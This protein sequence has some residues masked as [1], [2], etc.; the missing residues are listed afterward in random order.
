MSE[1]MAFRVPEELDGERID[2]VVAVAAGLSRAQAKQMVGTGEVTVDERRVAAS[3]RVRVGNAVQVVIPAPVADLVPADVEFDVVWEDDDL[4]VIDK[5]AGLVVH[6]GAGHSDDT[7]A[8]GLVGRYPELREL[9]PDYRWGLVHRLDRDTSGL[10]MV[11]KRQQAFIDLQQA[12]KAR[13]V[14]RTYLAMA[15]G[16]FDAATGTIDAPVGRDP[17]HPTRMTVRSDGRPARTHYRRVAQWQGVSLLE[18]RL[19]TGRTHQIRVH[20]AS[21]DRPVSGDRAYGRPGPVA[22]DPGRTWLHASRLS[23]PHP[24][25]GRE[26]VVSAP[27]PLDLASTFDALGAPDLGTVPDGATDRRPPT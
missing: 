7:L 16:T 1:T 10:L 13:R 11:A 14:G 25:D 19:E 9:G 21:I 27:L 3:H 22:A 20:L 5:P 12:L 6:P 4:L 23:L 17:V 2:R 8:N 15:V 18:L 26:I 24:E